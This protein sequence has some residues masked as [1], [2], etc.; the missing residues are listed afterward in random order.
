MEEEAGTWRKARA[1]T[2]AAGEAAEP[3]EEQRKGVRAE[4]EAGMAPH[5]VP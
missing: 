2:R 1:Y 3:R 5:Q 4:Q